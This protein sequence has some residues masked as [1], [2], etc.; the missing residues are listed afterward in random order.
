MTDKQLIELNKIP[1]NEF[2]KRSVDVALSGRHTITVIGNPN[3]GLNHLRSVFDNNVLEQNS[4][5]LTF[6]T[7]CP[8]GNFED[9]HLICNCQT[10]TI[11]EHIKTPEYQQATRSEI[12]IR[13][14]TPSFNDYSFKKNIDKTALELLRTACTKFYFTLSKINKIISVAETVAK[15]DGSEIVM[16]YHMAEAI[17]Y[18]IS[19]TS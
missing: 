9:N 18:Q 10:D 17:Q 19:L 6:I 15:M 1:G 14:L 8:C 13:L 16:P 5:L 12:I 4:S 11:L 3:N 2:L 7:P